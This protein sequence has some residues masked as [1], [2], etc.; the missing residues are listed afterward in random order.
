MAK[1]IGN[2]NPDRS[3][4]MEPETLQIKSANQNEAKQGQMWKI[5][6]RFS[7]K[8]VNKSCESQK[9]CQKR[10]LPTASYQQT[11]P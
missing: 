2:L 6:E 11:S 1:T 5:L 9:M 10:K 4:H 3:P 8:A 7:R